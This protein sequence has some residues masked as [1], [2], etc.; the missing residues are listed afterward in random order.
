VP[1]ASFAA[2]SRLWFQSS[3]PGAR[4]LSAGWEAARAT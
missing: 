3:P 4:H 2:I 1:D